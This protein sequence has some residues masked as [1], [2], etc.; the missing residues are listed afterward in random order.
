MTDTLP[1]H[2]FYTKCLPSQLLPMAD[3]D[4]DIHEWLNLSPDPRSPARTVSSPE[5]DKGSQQY[6]FPEEECQSLQLSSM[7]NDYFNCDEW[8]RSLERVVP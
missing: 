1:C 6:G 2:L 4:F 3:E 8:V 7:T 5:A